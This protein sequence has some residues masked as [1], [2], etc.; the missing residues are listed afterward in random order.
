MI[1]FSGLDGAGKSTQIHLLRNHLQFLN[2]NSEL[3]WSRGGYTPG[4]ES[5]K[6]IMRKLNSGLIPKER[7]NSEQRKESFSNPLVRKIWLSFS[8]LDLIFFYGIYIRTKELLNKVVICD[9][10]LF[11]TLLDFKLNFPQEKFEKWFIWRFLCSVAV[12]PKKYFV[13]TISVEESKKRSKLKDEPFP[14][15]EDTLNYRLSKYLDFVDDNKNVVHLDCS[16]GIK[17]IHNLI[18]KQLDI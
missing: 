17:N 6:N 13:L 7:G 9:R 8:I 10:Y 4:M 3:F 11:D 2:K 5:I 14:D 15:S 12:K 16:T 18:L 1:V